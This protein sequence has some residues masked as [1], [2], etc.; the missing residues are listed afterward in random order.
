[1]LVLRSF[2]ILTW[3]AVAGTL[4][5]FTTQGVSS[6][7]LAAECELSSGE[8]SWIQRAVSNWERASAELLRLPPEPLPW[9]V[10][11]DHEC[12]WYMAPDTPQ[13]TS[14]QLVSA[15]I[16]FRDEP[17]PLWSAPHQGNVR[18]P[19]GDS[20]AVEPR[21]YAAFSPRLERPYFVF[22]LPS[23]FRRDPA[24]A[25]DPLLYE[26]LLSVVSHEILHTRQLPDLS[27][28]IQALRQR[29]ALP[30]QLDDNV[31]ERTFGND[32]SFRRAFEAERD[33][34]YA[35]AFNSDSTRA[36]AQA[37]QALLLIEQ[38]RAT[39]FV[40]PH[41]AY[42]RLED[43]F[44]N[45]EGVAEWVRFKLHQTSPGPWTTDSEIADFMR[46]RN[47]EWVQDEGLAIY[48]LLERFA[49]NW[50]ERLLGSDL[51]SPVAVLVEALARQ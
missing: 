28:Q 30:E 18:L 36:R 22:A 13:H 10:L 33:L 1:M 7:Q 47:N 11:F 41:R 20:I 3:S 16:E 4:G 50:Q 14:T 35:A 32:T 27:R 25:A 9:I 45:M 19:T 8:V 21:V 42:G 43:L 5:C 26:R 39:F 6:P 15:D 38:R 12:T 17:V 40:G 44:L 23:V 31:I 24:A 29:D 37:A 34:L 51:E 49:V 48:L 46:G 2:P